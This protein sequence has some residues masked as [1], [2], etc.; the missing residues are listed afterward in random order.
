[1]DASDPEIEFDEQGVCN[2]C[3]TYQARV[4]KDLH[5]DQ[6]GQQKLQ[7]MVAMIK[8]K[9]KDKDYDCIVGVSGGVD[10]TYVAYQAKKLGLR[11]LAVH[12]DNGWDSELAVSNIEKVLKRL[13]IDLLSHVINW[14]EFRDLHLAFLRSSVANSEIPTDHAITAILYRIANEKGIQ[15]ILSGGN[16]VTEAIMPDSWMY[17]ARDLRHVKAIHK[18]FGSVPLR[19]F[20]TLGL[21]R[22]AYYIFIK[23]IKWIPILNYIPY[24]KEEAKKVLE[25]ELGW[26]SYG[27]KH[28]ESIYT[29]FFQG[30]I[31]PKKFG[32]DKRKAHLSTLICSGQITREQALEALQEDTY[33]EEQIQEDEEYVVKKLGLTEDEFEEIMR[34][35][36]KSSLEYPNN[37][38]LFQKFV[39]LLKFVKKVTTWS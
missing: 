16:L 11:P 24:H 1:M 8:E 22:A 19:T 29:R 21:L 18:K 39:F 14:K 10:S 6:T 15:Y 20:P 7:R 25:Q 27:A 32:I 26:R 17:D 37:A 2:H 35:P 30:Y 38:L 33:P 36:A 23:G 34:Q 31:L 12:L 28:Y 13:N 5:Y 3:R 4:K 9:G